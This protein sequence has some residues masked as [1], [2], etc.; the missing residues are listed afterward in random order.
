MAWRFW[1]ITRDTGHRFAPGSILKGSLCSIENASARF[2]DFR[3]IFGCRAFL[4]RGT[5]LNLRHTRVLRY[6]MGSGEA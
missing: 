1:Q 3:D 4:V 5:D 6:K 2:I